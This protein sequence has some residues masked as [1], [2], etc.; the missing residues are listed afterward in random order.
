MASGAIKKAQAAHKRERKELAKQK[1]QAKDEKRARE[2]EERKR[3]A[4]PPP[5]ACLTTHA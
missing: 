2:Y 3:C 4:S 5:N 1:K